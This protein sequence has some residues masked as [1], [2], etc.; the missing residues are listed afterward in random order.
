VNFRDVE[1]FRG[2]RTLVV[3]GGISATQF[4]L[5]LA[6]VT[7]TL[8]AT[9][10]PP[11]FTDREFDG[12]WGLEVERAV[13]DRTLSGLAPASVVR[14]T[15]LPIR[16]EFREGVDA[17]VLVSRGMFDRVLPHG[18]HFP[19]QTGD[20]EQATAEGL[21]PSASDRLAVPSP[22]RRLRPNAPR[23]ST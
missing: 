21:D 7:D 15:G 16:K 14:T 13:R 22:G 1:D 17:G 18:V 2:L 11:N 4:L 8:W 12:Q 9:R 5:Q 3:G 10:R 6:E 19:G 23:R 20:S